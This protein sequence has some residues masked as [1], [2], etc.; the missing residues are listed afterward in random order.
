[1]PEILGEIGGSWRTPGLFVERGFGFCVLHEE[2]IVSW[3]L[4]ENNGQAGCEL[5][6]ETVEGYE[7]RGL[8]LAVAAAFVG[9]CRAVGT[10]PFWHAAIENKPSL[11][12]AE[13][14]GFEL[15]RDYSIL[16]LEPIA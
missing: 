14:A 7:R 6:I 12:L 4:S 3:C 10:A 8:G 13:R 16:R 15:E 2:A 9:H 1:M 11:L 5:G